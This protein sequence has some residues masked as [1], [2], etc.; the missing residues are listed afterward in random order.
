MGV[1]FHFNSTVSAIVSEGDRVVMHIDDRT[2]DADAVVIAA[3]IDSVRLLEPLGIRVPL[4][5]V[6]GYAATV[7]IKNF[8][9]APLAAVVDESYKV[10]ITRMGNRIRLAGTAELG[11][12][13]LGLR[14]AALRTLVKVGDDW[15]SDAANYNTATFWCGIRPMLPD[16][17]PVLGSTPIRNVFLN[18]GHGSAGW[19]MAAGSGKVVADIVS[20][21][22]PDI[23]MH[24]LT[25]ARYG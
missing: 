9:Q 20:G 3:G 7:F 18:I 6:K 24:G 17:P 10:A 23:D 11:S 14:E 21:Q 4:C 16:G 25:L 5:P 1:E 12:R 19:V 8:D 15:F 22:E 13:T 2:F